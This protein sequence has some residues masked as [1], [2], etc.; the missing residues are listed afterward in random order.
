[1]AKQQLILLVILIASDTSQAQ[2]DSDRLTR[3]FTALI[4][5]RQSSNKRV[6]SQGASDLPKLNE[7]I[8]AKRYCGFDHLAV[9]SRIQYRRWY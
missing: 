5:Y 4:I 6:V 7:C 3:S 2:S 9:P 1:M 8:V